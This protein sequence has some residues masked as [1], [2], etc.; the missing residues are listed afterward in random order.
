MFEFIGMGVFAFIA[1]MMVFDLFKLAFDIVSFCF[2][3]KYE[4]YK[5]IERR[6]R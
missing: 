5:K 1:V 6:K 3:K 4:D 2:F